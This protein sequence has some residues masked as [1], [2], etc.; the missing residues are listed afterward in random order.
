[1]W[2]GTLIVQWFFHIPFLYMLQKNYMPLN[3]NVKRNKKLIYMGNFSKSI[4]WLSISKFIF[5]P[6]YLIPFLYSPKWTW[7]DKLTCALHVHDIYF[8]LDKIKFKIDII[9]DKLLETIWEHKK[10]GKIVDHSLV[11]WSNTQPKQ[12]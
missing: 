5:K 3:S 9:N 2:K 6:N 7:K 11:V 4:I 10:R 1:M 8:N 12:T